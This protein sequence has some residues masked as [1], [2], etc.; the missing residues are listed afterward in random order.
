[1]QDEAEV[2]LKTLLYLRSNQIQILVLRPILIYPHTARSNSALVT[3][4]VNLAQ[5]TIHV[6]HTL[7]TK[8]ELYSRRQAIFNHFLS[9]ALTVLFLTA[10]YDAEA[11]VK[12]RNDQEKQGKFLGDAVAELQ[13]GLELIDHL[14]PTS[15]SATR[16]W[17]RFSR[18]RQQLVQLGILSSTGTGQNRMDGLDSMVR[19]QGQEPVQPNHV[20]DGLHVHPDMNTVAE[21]QDLAFESYIPFDFDS[22]SFE[23]G[24]GLFWQDWFEGGCMDSSIP[25][26]MPAWM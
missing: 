15:Q 23:P 2:F 3:D 4:A 9:S 16:L 18:P 20:M 5:R 17:I 22:S 10:A 6:L 26:G 24:T 21:H 14:R 7:V 19:S 11:Q 12:R 13:T 1:M 25:F 8:T